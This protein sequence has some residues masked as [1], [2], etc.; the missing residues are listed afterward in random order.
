MKTCK[1]CKEQKREEM[2]PRRCN[3]CKECKKLGHKLAIVT[4]PNTYFGWKP[5]VP[6]EKSAPLDINILR[7]M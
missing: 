6:K 2:F 4:T 7:Y 1:L 3:T 5:Y